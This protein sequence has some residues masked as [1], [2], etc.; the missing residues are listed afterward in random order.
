VTSGSHETQLCRR[1]FAG[2]INLPVLVL[3][4][5]ELVRND[6]AAEPTDF[7]A[8]AA[9]ERPAEVAPEERTLE[10]GRSLDDTPP[11][12][13]EPAGEDFV[14]ID[15]P[16]DGTHPESMERVEIHLS[17]GHKAL[18]VHNF[19]SAEECA[20]L[21][22]ASRVAGFR[23]TGYASRVRN[24]D[25]VL[26]DC[27]E[28]AAQLF[29][30]I[31][32]LLGD[33]AVVLVD[34][35]G[36][37]DFGV[38]TE[39]TWTADGLNCRFR[40]CRYDA[41]GH[42]SPHCD[43]VVALDRHRR[44]FLTFMVYLDS[45]PPERGGATRFLAMPDGATQPIVVDGK[46]R[47]VAAPGL[48]EAAF[49]PRRGSVIIFQQCTILHDGEPLVDGTKHIFRSDVMFSRD[50]DTAPSHSPHQA[51]ALDLLQRAMK[52]EG[53]G[54]FALATSLYSRAYKLYPALETARI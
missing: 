43:G 52:A 23:P 17:G 51:R 31:E 29:R 50:P 18:V 44:S 37:R 2:S 38:G 54:D 30:R 28:L 24:C 8:M 33:Q 41:G 40:S 45:V 53:D 42:F 5:F 9:A 35:A 11:E 14:R 6:P 26:L 47:L 39:G 25:R 49:Q 21:Q 7:P 20:A 32:P 27:P 13:T 46:D 16:L 36:A 12:G 48:V 10:A 19:L 15:S 1:A 22:H 3:I 34:S 4:K